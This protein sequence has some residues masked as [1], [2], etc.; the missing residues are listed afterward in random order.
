MGYNSDIEAYIIVKANDVAL[1]K[2]LLAMNFALI[3]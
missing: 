1:T 3:V 2:R